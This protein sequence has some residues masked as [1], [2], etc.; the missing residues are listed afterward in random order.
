MKNIELELKKF[1]DD[2]NYLNSRF[3]DQISEQKNTLLALKDTHVKDVEELN[4]KFNQAELQIKENHEKLAQEIFRYGELLKEKYKVEDLSGVLKE[5][6][7][8]MEAA[9]LEYAQFKIKNNENQHQ[10]SINKVE[11][12]FET[13]V[14]GLEKSIS[15]STDEFEIKKEL[16]FQ[17]WEQ[18]KA[19]LIDNSKT[20]CHPDLLKNFSEPSVNQVC[21]KISIGERCIEV[22]FGNQIK[23]ISYPELIS[24]NDS[25]NLVV[26]YDSEH[27]SKAE[28]ISDVLII[29]VLFSNLP[30]KLKIHL[31][32]NNMHEKFREF[33]PIPKTVIQ[34]GF[35]WG[36]FVN[37]LTQAE[38]I[39]RQK[40]GLLWSDL[41]ASHTSIHEYNLNL[42]KEEKYDEILPYFLFVFDDFLGFLNDK[43]TSDSLVKL[44]K[45]LHYGCNALFLVDKTRDQAKFEEF[46]EMTKGLSLYWLDLTESSK[47]VEGELSHLKIDNLNAE[48]KKLL[49]QN[50][51]VSYDNLSSSRAKIKFKS[52]LVSE[53]NSWFKQT[54]FSEVKIPIGK[55]EL[56][57]GFE[58]LSFKTKD[59]LSNAL[60]CGGV[61][62]GKTNFLKTVITSL[63]LNY[64]PTE[65]ELWLV[66]MKNGAGFSIFNNNQLPHATK[67]AFSAESELIND[68]FFQL[69]K[70]MEE[71]YAYFAQFSVDNLADAAT[72][73]NIDK[74]KLRRIV[75]II[76]EFATIFTD[77]AAYLDEISSN[78][79]SIIQKG[80][81]M[82]INLLLAAQ[83]FNNI[84]NTSFN[85][86]VT[87][88]PTR[89]LLKSSPE[90][91]TSVLGYTNKGS[92]EI[93]K[94]GQGLI[95]NNFGE[96]NN[97]GGNFFF[98]SF[99]LDN[100]DLEPILA[101]LK[102]EIV[103]QKIPTS[104]VKFIDASSPAKFELNQKL[105]SQLDN[106]DYGIAFHK[107]GLDCYLGESYLMNEDNH[108]SFKW[109]ING[110]QSLQNIIISG[111]ERE[112]SSQAL[113]SILSSL[114]Y[115][116]P[117]GEIAIKWLNALDDDSTKDLCL[118]LN[119]S[120]LS[121]YDLQTF[122][123][124]QLEVL[125][126]GIENIMNNRRSNKDRIPVVVFLIGLEKLVKLHSVSFSE[127]E[128]TTRLKM[129]MSSGSN[130]GIYFVC[131]IN[132]PSN[133]DKISRDL[134]GFFEHR[135]CFFMNADESN[136]LLTSKA[137]SQLINMDAPNIRNKAI[138][139][140][141][142]EALSVKYKSYD[143]LPKSNEL[144]RYTKKND[145]NLSIEP[146]SF[147]SNE[148]ELINESEND[149]I[150]FSLK[151]ALEKYP[152]LNK[153]FKELKNE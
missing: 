33:L 141:Q 82:G 118:E 139:F 59:M 43:N 38:E 113:F 1:V 143:G 91:A 104:S 30:D 54:A 15:V 135:I 84:R 40:L 103:L 53:K 129:L 6:F 96:I 115:G 10:E 130:Y 144:I 22:N 55:S 18:F 57:E 102:S 78:L 52:Y 109:K 123:I 63:S 41:G 89:I 134:V 68:L 90:A 146:L 26:V 152:H 98:R 107:S 150:E 11:G 29:R 77:E 3:N 76:D 106:E 121:N 93:T 27:L 56:R 131:E 65:L 126:A 2:F 34:N 8:E 69:K 64:S 122:S 111:N 17:E 21:D 45:L 114:S 49:I 32:D 31:Y 51:L 4:I 12:A 138:Y 46:R 142:S 39:I 20:I 137:A 37:H 125:I 79:L 61:G 72:L 85:Q 101:D 148:I 25:Q 23:N 147:K 67:Y 13:A 81:A 47:D 48:D 88:I 5:R 133:L 127:P 9:I 73:E 120:N 140:S 50:F 71:R 19:E 60:L 70:E 80:R 66:D 112:H 35:E 14:D 74:S 136:Y 128:L 62:S 132:K 86:A 145:M 24:F 97:D 108:F 100:D 58:F 153:Q 119:Y 151:S 105:F 124:E 83:N 95:N 110:R 117:N 149:K 44:D 87:L 94:I 42:I 28:A 116:T 7:K 36:H 75:L 16:L 99:I 92:V